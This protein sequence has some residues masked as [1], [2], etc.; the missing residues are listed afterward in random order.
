[1]YRGTPPRERQ[2]LPRSFKKPLQKRA[3]KLAMRKRLSRS[4]PSRWG[5][6]A[7]GEAKRQA[8]TGILVSRSDHTKQP[9]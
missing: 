2:K 6:Q 7:R 4:S 3:K 9:L 1:L 8:A 5:L